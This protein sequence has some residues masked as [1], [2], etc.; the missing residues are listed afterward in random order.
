MGLNNTFPSGYGTYTEMKEINCLS[1]DNIVNEIEK[2]Y[3]RKK[4]LK[5]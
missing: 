1:K 5:G 3:E 2:L 4:E